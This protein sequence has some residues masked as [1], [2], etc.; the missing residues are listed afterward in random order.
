MFAKQ[1]TLNAKS[2][3]ALNVYHEPAKG[4]P[5]GIVTI[6]HGIAEHAARYANFAQTLSAKGY[7]VYAH[8]HRGHGATKV[9][10]ASLGTFAKTDGWQRVL[11]DTLEIRNH[12]KTAHPD[13]PLVLFGHSM[14][15][16][17]SLNSAL[18]DPVGVAAL[19]V[20]NANFSAG[21]LGRV[22]QMILMA[23]RMMLGSDVPSMVLPKLTFQDW[24]KKESD[25][26]TGYDWLSHDQAQ[27]DAYLAD[28]LCGWDASV[29]MW[30]DVFKLVFH[31]AN[32]ANFAN[33]PKAL[34]INL[35]G[36][37]H[38]P[39]TEFGKATMQLSERLSKMGF[40]NVTT[41]IGP[42]NRHECLNDT[43]R[44]EVVDKFVLWLEEILR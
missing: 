26:R 29:G 34:P 30:Q 5:R 24:A 32:D 38:D 44:D 13:L 9:P 19:A 23:E 18:R 27:V 17:I 16:L 3:A 7:H 25:G 10:G 42:D 11:D 15:G 21:L 28:P 35:R 37:G 14:G 31:G 36:G 6:D 39:A 41:A 33:L 40:S 1:F 2:G 22:G 4:T 12:A 8:D 43:N 20:W